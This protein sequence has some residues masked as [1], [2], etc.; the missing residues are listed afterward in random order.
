L[1]FSPQALRVVPTLLISKRLSRPYLMEG[2]FPAEKL[3]G[4]EEIRREHPQSLLLK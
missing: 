3:K 2:D 4:E 1:L